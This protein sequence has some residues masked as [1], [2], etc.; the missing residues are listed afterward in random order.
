[1]KKKIIILGSTGS[2]GKSTLDVIKNDKKNFDIVLLYANNNYIKL[3]EQAKKFKAR[4]VYIKNSDFYTKIKN[5]LKKTK[6]KVFTGNVKLDKI[7]TTKNR[8]YHVMYCWIGW[9]TAYN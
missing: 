4:N 5:A 1:M 2:I 7:V 9:I 3:I 8:L 6:T